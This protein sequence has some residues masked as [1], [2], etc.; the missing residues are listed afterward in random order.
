MRFLENFIETPLAGAIGWTML[1][2]LWEGA[3]IA[4]ALGAALLVMRSARL[5]YAA[6]CIAMAMMLGGFALTW[7]HLLPDGQNAFWN[8]QSP[9]LH[10]WNG[11][12]ASNA[13]GYWDG[14]LAAIVPW[15]APLWIAGV[16]AFYLRHVAGL[17]ALYRLRHRGVCCAPECW[18][19]KLAGL[20]ARLHLS[21]P[22][23][24]L[25]SSLADTPMVIGHLRPLVLMP[26]GILT[27]LPAAQIEAVLL[28]ELAHIGRYDYIV[29]TLQRL[30]EG[31]LFY[32]P[33]VWWIS[34]V[35]RT[36]RENCCD[37]MVVSISGNAHQYAV[38]LA[39]LEQN[40]WSGREPAV[41]AIG[42]SLVNRIHR[43]LYPKGPSNAWTPFFAAIALLVT[44]GLCLGA[45]ESGVRGGVHAI[46]APHSQPAEAMSATYSKWLNEDVVY[47]ISDEER[48][49]FQRLN[50]NEERDKFIE[51][52]W[53]RRDPTPGTAENEFKT[54]H[55]RRIAYVNKH[56]QNAGGRQGWQTD[57]GRIYILY[58]PPDEIESHPNGGP[59]QSYP[60]EM[61]AY[62]HRPAT[63]DLDVFTF[64]DRARTGDYR[65]S[66]STAK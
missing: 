59:R 41:A 9:A 13:P 40:R 17:R 33:A 50:T 54:E 19:S 23:L 63:A 11:Q 60:N 65:L 16:L 10:Q 51:Q 22:I 43:L 35:I 53:L 45:W 27:G 7:I 49:A 5:R 8:L 28:H 52:F 31:L 34:R 56:Y 24:L 3:I 1:H 32:H 4:A 29:N 57:R 44:A 18:Q 46:P 14:D 21:R 47:I 12:L 64:I 36:E 20:S 37:D 25:E 30:V 38:A 58:G 62:R 61:W 48:A 2:S 26:V 39:A 66:S 42:G 6:A 15:L 55:Y